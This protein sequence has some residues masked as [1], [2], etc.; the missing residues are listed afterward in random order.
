MAVEYLAQL[1]TE[2]YEYQGYFVRNGL[3]VGLE[4]DGSY[5]CVLDVVAFHPLRHHVVHIEPSLDLLSF[6]E[7]ERHFQPKF[8]AG[9]RYL[10]RLFGTEPRTHIEQIALILAAGN[11]PHQMI[12]GGKIVQQADLLAEIVKSLSR[13]DRACEPVPERW[14]LIRTLQLVCEDRQRLFPTLRAP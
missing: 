12:G 11:I 1:V 4:S 8:D 2:W 13:V 3:W 14:P 9:R 6:D 5:E 10:H 7:K